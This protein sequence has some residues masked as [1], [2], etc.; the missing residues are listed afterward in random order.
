MGID[1]MSMYR[2]G[3]KLYLRGIP[4]LPA[5]LR[6]AIHYLHGS[7]IPAETEIGEGTQLGYGGMG[8]VIHKDA[9]I[10][11]HCLIS[12]QVTIGGRSGLKDLPV[13]GDYVRIGAGAKILG[14]VRIGDFAVIGANAVVVKDVAPGAVVGGIPAREIRRDADPLAAYERE[15]GLRPPMPRPESVDSTESPQASSAAQ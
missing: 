11:R 14:N 7:Y 13:I 8:I 12:H 6:K 4:V 15:M 9:R 3:R 2:L 5:V 1:A 10:G